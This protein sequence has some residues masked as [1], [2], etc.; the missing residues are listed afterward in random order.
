[1]PDTADKFI[2]AID[3][4]GTMT[5][6]ILFREDGTFHVGKALTNR[7]NET[8]SYMESVVDAAGY[9]GL[10][11]ADVHGRTSVLLI[12]TGTAI[13]NTILTLSGAR[14]GLMVSPAAGTTS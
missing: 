6:C 14:V 13:L 8:Q 4:G 2:V 7:E 12:Y 10:T 1:M 9:L 11:S 3:A 5:D